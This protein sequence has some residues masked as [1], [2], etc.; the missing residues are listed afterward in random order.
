MVSAP[1][2]L[3]INKCKN[4]SSNNNTNNNT[5]VNRS[6]GT[7]INGNISMPTLGNDQRR[8]SSLF[9]SLKD[10]YLTACEK[11]Q[12]LRYIFLANNPLFILL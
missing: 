12:R 2:I 3:K 10:Q 9:N 6:F 4:S 8:F 11:M 7:T 1:N 5:Q